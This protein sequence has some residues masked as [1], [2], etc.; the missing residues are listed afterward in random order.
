MDVRFWSCE[1]PKMH[2]TIFG[3][4]NHNKFSSPPH[5]TSLLVRSKRAIVSGLSFTNTLNVQTIIKSKFMLD[6]K[7][8]HTNSSVSFEQ[9]IIGKHWISQAVDVVTQKLFCKSTR[10]PWC[11]NG[12]YC[13]HNFKTILTIEIKRH[14]E[15]HKANGE[16]LLISLAI[17]ALLTVSKILT[18]RQS[19]VVIAI[20]QWNLMSCDAIILL[21][22]VTTF[23]LHC[24][25]NQQNWNYLLIQWNKATSELMKLQGRAQFVEESDRRKS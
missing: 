23:R 14:E 7:Q 5:E 25:S 3:Q 9:L 19:I 8:F 17:S 20:E 16:F 11:V 2:G 24:T 18:C 4:K 13:L 1:Y 10:R 12:Q 15:Q 22:C 6:P 21:T